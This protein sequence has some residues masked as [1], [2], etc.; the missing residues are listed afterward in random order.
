VSRRAVVTW[1]LLWVFVMSAIAAGVLV[2]SLLATTVSASRPAAQADSPSPSGEMTTERPT[3]LPS[4]DSA[5]R[6]ERSEPA[7]LR[8]SV[9]GAG[10]RTPSP[11][12]AVPSRPT[13]SMT[14]APRSG[15]RSAGVASTYGPGWDGW[16]ALPQGPGHRVRIC[17]AGGC[18]IR[19]S[20]DA[21]PSLAMQRHP[22]HRVADLDVG[23]FEAVCGKPWTA[24]LCNVSVTPWK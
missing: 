8:A 3:A 18:V 23:T 13:A 14:P 15:T 9:P 24:G 19:T 4:P 16:L 1:A 2:G 17:G 21:G 5:R 11:S 20:N 6:T 12:A 22:Y 10:A 7:A